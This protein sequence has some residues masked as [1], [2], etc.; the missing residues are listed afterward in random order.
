MTENKNGEEDSIDMMDNNAIWDPDG[1]EMM[2]VAISRKTSEWFI[3]L[4]K[5]DQFVQKVIE[6]LE[7]QRLL[8]EQATNEDEFVSKYE[9][10][11][12]EGDLVGA[13]TINN[14]RYRVELC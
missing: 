14:K 10:E 5:A 9:D 3:I 6:E 4:V 2:L 11:D 13:H 7:Q 8:N 12:E 1:I